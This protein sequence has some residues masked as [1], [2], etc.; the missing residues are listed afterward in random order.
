M[1]Y[2]KADNGQEQEHF[3]YLEELRQ[4]GETNMY[5]AAPYLGH[6]FGLDREEA[7]AVLGKWMRLHSDSKRA[8][9]KPVTKQRPHRVVS[10][11]E[12]T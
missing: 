5:G 4:S 3:D 10:R 1:A 11:F 12:E 8:L 7:C 6:A 9:D 2:I